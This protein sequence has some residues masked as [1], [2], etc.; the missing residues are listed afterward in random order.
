MKA[1]AACLA[2][3]L[4]VPLSLAGPADAA[5]RVPSERA[6]TAPTAPEQLKHRGFPAARTARIKFGELPVRRILQVQQRNADARTRL[7]QIGVGRIAALE[8][9]ATDL[10]L[11]W[12]ALPDG[13]HV[14]RL[15]VTSPVALGLRVGAKATALD[16]RMQLRFAGS[17][18]PARV[19]AV[20]GGGEIA[21]LGDRRGVFW[22]PSTDGQT[23]IIELHAPPGVP[24]ARTT[25]QVP[26]ISHLLTNSANDYK[27]IAKIGESGSCNVDTACRVAE[28]G[29]P[30]VSAK[31]AVAQMQ[32]NLFQT[33]GSIAGTYICTGTLLADTDAST[34][35]PY[36]YT[37]HHCFAGG[38]SGVPVQT[39][40]QAVANTLN[41]YWQY[42]ATACG[43][44]VQAAR[45]LLGGGADFLYSSAGTDAMLLR[46]RNAPP[47]GSEFAGWNSALLATS[48]SVIG[49]H[50]PAGDAK[51]VSRGQQ[52]ARDAAQIEVGWLSGTTEGGSSGSGIFTADAGGYALRGGLYGG[53]ASCANAGS[54]A[55]AGNRD[56]Y[57]RFDVVYPN[58]SQY[59]APVVSAPIR[60]N[61]SQPLVPPATQAASASAPA[62]SAVESKPSNRFPRHI[63]RREG[64]L[65]P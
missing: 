63:A 7:T 22:T 56:Y 1:V 39:S 5:Q 45:V 64:P 53:S 19:V 38:S 15:E 42:E 57:S 4:L 3:C 54:L 12:V 18:D 61:G 47:A 9:E 62:R 13:G 43:S 26:E 30:F 27:I 11:A 21:A 33:S 2:A 44:G 52:T 46:L 50:H 55:N 35:V 48:S 28:L 49:I 41:T 36:F 17:D 24:H 37:A 51:K 34:Q 31:N 23:Q 59:L 6:T 20:L 32:Y 60:V 25:L 40:F 65:E 8:A 58:I 10:A 14:A 29:A 16:P